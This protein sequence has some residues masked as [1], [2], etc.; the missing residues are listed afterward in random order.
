MRYSTFI[1]YPTTA[2]LAIRLNRFLP[3]P[4]LGIPLGNLGYSTRVRG[5]NPSTEW[6]K[7]FQ[8][9]QFFL[10]SFTFHSWLSF[11]FH[12]PIRDAGNPAP[13]RYAPL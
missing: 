2:I 3:H 1:F 13:E 11:V 12:F 10:R 7:F 6:I 8:L 9:F 5:C 4:I